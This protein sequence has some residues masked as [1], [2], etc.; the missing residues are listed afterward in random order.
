MS[1]LRQ[2]NRSRVSELRGTYPVF[3]GVLGQ[4]DVDGDED[5][6]TAG[7]SL[8]HHQDGTGVGPVALVN[9]RAKLHHRY[10]VLSGS[11]ANPGVG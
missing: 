4:E 5:G 6:G 9:P 1:P 7:S 2:P 8:T 3:S 10:G 11:K